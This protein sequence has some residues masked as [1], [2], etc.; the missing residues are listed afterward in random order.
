[1]K[2]SIQV[3]LL[4]VIVT[5]IVVYMYLLESLP[6]MTGQVPLSGL[7]SPVV[8]TQDAW[9]IPHIKAN[10]KVD[11]FRSLGY[12]MA[13]SRL[14]QMDLY[15]RLAQGRLSEVVGQDGL[16]MDIR[17][18][19]L[20][21]Y[22]TALQTIEQFR[23]EFGEEFWELMT[24]YFEG[25]NTYVKENKLPY[26]FDLLGYRP[27]VFAPIDAFAMLGLMSYQMSHDLQGDLSLSRIKQIHGEDFDLFTVNGFQSKIETTRQV[28]S[29]LFFN[30]FDLANLTGQVNLSLDSFFKITGSNAWA[31]SAD[32]TQSG[33]P[34][35][36]ND[37]HMGFSTPN[38]WFEAHLIAPEFEIYGHFL[39]LIP[40][41]IIGHNR[42]LAWGMTM[43]NVDVMDFYQEKMDRVKKVIISK[44]Q[45]VSYQQREEKILID[46]GKQDYTI[47]VETG[48]HGPL[49]NPFF[50]YK[51]QAP[52][53]SDIA[54][55]WTGHDLKNLSLL[56]LWKMNSSH[57]ISEFEQALSLGTGPGINIIYADKEKNIAWWTYGK[58]PL[59]PS[60]VEGNVLLEGD[61]G[62]H[63]WVG[64]LPFEKHPKEVNPV[65]GFVLSANS[66]PEPADAKNIEIQGS[67]QPP[68]RY[69][70]LLEF[71]K[72]DGIL[73][74]I[75]LT[76]KLQTLPYNIHNRE[77]LEVLLSSLDINLHKNDQLF[78]NVYQILNQWD[79]HSTTQA[80]APSAF[81]LWVYYLFHNL[82]D[83]WKEL[84]DG[85]E[86]KQLFCDYPGKEYFLDRML[87]RPDHL[88]WDLKSTSNRESKN[89]IVK[90]SF[91]KM[92][93]HL[94][95]VFGPD[96]GQWTWGSLNRVTFKHP[97]GGIPVIGSL[98]NRG[99]FPVSGAT[100]HIAPMSSSDCD[101]QFQIHSGP[102]TRRIIDFAHIEKSK[103][104]LPLGN[105]GHMLSK[106]Y[107][108]QTPLFLGGRY[109][110]QLMDEK[111]YKEKNFKQWEYMPIE[112]DKSLT[113]KQTSKEQ[114]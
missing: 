108:D 25:V 12:Q 23:L 32:R 19:V 45:E 33:M 109:R 44:G 98:L 3:S 102:S 57:Q 96:F 6:V 13:S 77:R 76:Q 43:S 48:P 46:K 88:L 11:L 94:T 97:L 107:D 110:D 93:K 67:W 17:A 22:P 65:K 105:S 56:A 92:L 81:H 95:H 36:A 42:H 82:V 9:G 69:R 112:S 50:N 113:T 40:F 66:R 2:T 14:F 79:G 1:M 90:L 61:H 59:R 27:E 63:D 72:K 64:Y 30:G 8:V 18:R 7:S 41:A 114:I 60:G 34:L 55:R 35:F 5:S 38:I 20:G 74:D 37:P 58:I 26:E 52:L 111:D 84:K 71:L 21:F 78:N 89:D 54:I 104:I 103:G 73:W 62:R 51:R 91:E 4:G 28:S 70:S 75:P 15:K 39:P 68:Y 106:H 80:I 100:H 24:A 99:P 101:P 47:L 87:T 29:S 31:I 16:F 86:L 83:E 10:S 53:E 49:I 85:Q